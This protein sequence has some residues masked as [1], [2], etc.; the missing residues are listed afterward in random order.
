[1][2]QDTG[3]VSIRHCIVTVMQLCICEMLFIRS[4]IGKIL[5]EPAQLRLRHVVKQSQWLLG[6]SVSHAYIVKRGYALRVSAV[7]IVSTAVATVALK[8]KPKMR[9]TSATIGYQAV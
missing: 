2:L 5:Q 7:S 6:T 4:V 3:Q 1:M 9:K 8:M